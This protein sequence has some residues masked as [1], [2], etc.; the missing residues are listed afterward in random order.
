[1]LETILNIN[2][3]RM[4]V[5]ELFGTIGQPG[6]TVEFVRMLRAIEENKRIRALVLDV[7]SPGGGRRRRSSSTA[8][9]AASRSRSR[10]WR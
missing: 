1:M 7:D 3:E 6:R 5:V 9:S 8:R 10:W 4:A 2:P